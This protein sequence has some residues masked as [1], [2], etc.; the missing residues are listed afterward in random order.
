[1][2]LSKAADDKITMHVKWDHNLS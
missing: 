2:N 1:V